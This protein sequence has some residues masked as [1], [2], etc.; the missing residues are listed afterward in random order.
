MTSAHGGLQMARNGEVEILALERE[1][2]Q[3][4]YGV[5]GK[6]IEIREFELSN[7]FRWIAFNLMP[8]RMGALTPAQRRHVLRW[9]RLFEQDFRVDKWSLCR[10]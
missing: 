10:G 9:L 6:S 5:V 4:G 7:Q 1:A 2:S 3:L 8:E